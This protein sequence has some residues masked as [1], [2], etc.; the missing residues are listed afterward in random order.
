[1]N[2]FFIIS[3]EIYENT[4]WQANAYCNVGPSYIYVGP[5]AGSYAVNTAIF[6]SDPSFESFRILLESCPQASLS[7]T[8]L[9]DPQQEEEA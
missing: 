9:I 2:T 7:P 5:H 3:P 8:D 1:M 4:N 6:A